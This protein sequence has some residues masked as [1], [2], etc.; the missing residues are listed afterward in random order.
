[1]TGVDDTADA[2]IGVDDSS[3]HLF[4]RPINPADIVKMANKLRSM[5][6]P[7]ISNLIKGQLSDIQSVVRVEV[8]KATVTL[9]EEIG[10]LREENAYLRKVNEDLI[11]RLD[12]TEG[13]NE[14]LE[15]YTR[16]VA[17]ALENLAILSRR[18]RIQTRVFLPLRKHLTFSCDRQI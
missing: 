10:N 9:K 14:A 2:T 12:M 3:V 5:M 8:E 4:S 15:Q 11:T 7:E 17:T 1:M 16:P 18:M 6:L 13:N